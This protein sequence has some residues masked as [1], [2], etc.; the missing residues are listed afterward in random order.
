MWRLCGLTGGAMVFAALC[1]GCGS[2]SNDDQLVM[3]FLRFNSVG[4]EQADS[5]RATSADV[6][7]WPPETCPSGLSEPFTQTII[8]AVFRNNEASDIMLNYLTVDFPPTS[9]RAVVSHGLSG[10]LTGGRCSNV[11]KQCATDAEC[12]SAS[13]TTPG[14]CEHTEMTVPGILLFDF[15]DKAHINPG[16]YTVTITFFGSDPNRSFE[17]STNYAVRFD[18]FDNCPSGG[19]GA[20]GS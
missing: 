8:N 14:S 18:D 13:S 11:D 3:E 6:D 17:T 7:I 19:G 10:V 4:I 5:V 2:T 9:G 12:V 1:V 16:T 15:D 20:A